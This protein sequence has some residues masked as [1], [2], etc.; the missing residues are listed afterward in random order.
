MGDLVDGE[1]RIAA[2]ARSPS[3]PDA[4]LD[5]VAY[6]REHGMPKAEPF[7][8]CTFAVVAVGARLDRR[9]ANLLAGMAM[10]GISRTVR[11]AHTLFDFDA[12][13]TLG[14]GKGRFDLEALGEAAADLVAEALL[15]GATG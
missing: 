3:D 4:F 10:A 8:N 13:I 11:P 12:I 5:T 7:S 2:G 15:R 1:G 9:S 6:L 14:C